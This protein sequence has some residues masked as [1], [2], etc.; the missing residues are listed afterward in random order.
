VLR[1]PK[2]LVV[3]AP[4]VLVQLDTKAM[5]LGRG[6]TVYEFSAVD[7]FTRKRVVALAVGLRSRLG[8]A[9]LRRL[10]AQFPFPVRAV[11]TDGGSDFR[12]EFRQAA[13]ALGLVHYVNHPYHPQGT[14]RVERAFRTDEEEFSQVVDLPDDLQAVAAALAA[15]NAIDETVRP[16]QALGYLT[17]D[18]FYARW[19]AAQ[20][21]GEE[22]V[23]DMS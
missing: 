3:D 4:G 1:R 18:E 20:H 21:E 23:S 19:L 9:F 8:A 16:H 11:Q 13:R 17:P 10:V 22:A 6:R 12:G 7:G 14:G 15:W 2:G 5:P